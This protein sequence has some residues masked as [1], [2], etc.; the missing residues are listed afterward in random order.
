MSAL[1]VPR[2]PR[3]H[4]FDLAVAPQSPAGSCVL[5][6]V[7]GLSASHDV[8]VFSSR[9]EVPPAA[10]LRWVRIPLPQ[11][12]LVLRYAA[13]QV[14]APLQAA[15]QRWRGTAPPDLVQTTQGQY[16]GADIAYAHFCHRAYLQGPWRQSPVRGLRRALR[17]LNHRWNAATE[18]RAFER[19]RCIVVPSRGLA[20]ELHAVYPALAGRVATLPNPVDLEAFARPAD[21][22]RRALRASLGLPADALVLAF[23]ALGDFARKG[24]H[25]VLGA[26]ALLPAAQRGTVRVLV[27]GGRGG[28]IEAA[29]AQAQHLGVAEQVVFTGLQPDVRRHLWAADLFAFPSA[30]EIFSLAVLQAAAAELPVL[31]SEGLYGAEEFVVDG[32]NGW[33]V[34]RTVEGVHAALA[35]ALANPA[36]VARMGRAARASV[37]RYSRE[38]FV[39]RWQALLASL[40][41]TR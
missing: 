1:P 20:R 28:E 33:V 4:V 32:E 5:A 10:G 41:D 16:P 27:V 11:R 39:A 17:W 13:F 30:Y 14:L 12:P 31:V 19:A 8:T 29:R 21:L 22:G 7:A 6:E 25:L 35:R 36:G 40:A 9:C 23:V 2:R 24:L 26:L 3:L 38:A 15:W 37:A 18:R 34:P